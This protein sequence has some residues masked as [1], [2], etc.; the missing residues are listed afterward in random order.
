MKKAFLFVL[1]VL[2]VAS[3]TAG[4]VFRSRF[5]SDPPQV[6]VSAATD[7]I[8]LAPFEITVTDSG[9]GLRSVTATISQGGA[10]QSLANDQYPHP[11][12][13]KKI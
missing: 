2:A 6:S 9:S 1:A 7:S 4:V 12:P 11:I 3:I 10:E 5:E 8:G 13:E